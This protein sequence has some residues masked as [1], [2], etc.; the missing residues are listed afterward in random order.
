MDWQSFAKRVLRQVRRSFQGGSHISCQHLWKIAKIFKNISKA[1]LFTSRVGLFQNPGKLCLQWNMF[2][3]HP[4]NVFYFLNH[5]KANILC[6][7]PFLGYISMQKSKY[8]FL[9]ILHIFHLKLCQVWVS[10]RLSVWKI[11]KVLQNLISQ[12]SSQEI[13]RRIEYFLVFL[14]F[15]IWINI[16]FRDNSSKNCMFDM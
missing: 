9:Y 10:Q 4:E 13:I 14:D 3:N 12:N 11:T 16:C 8:V 2:G 5:L 15:W 7:M 6:C 1:V